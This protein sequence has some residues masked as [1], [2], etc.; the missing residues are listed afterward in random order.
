LAIFDDGIINFYNKEYTHDVKV[1]LDKEI[2]K[3]KSDGLLSK[4]QI[5]RK[6]N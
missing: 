6:M 5:M 2:V 4:G 3:V 1:D